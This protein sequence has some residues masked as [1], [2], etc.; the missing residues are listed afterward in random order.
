M[1]CPFKKRKIDENDQADSIA[2]TSDEIILSSNEN[3]IDQ[4]EIE[5][6]VQQEQ[7]DVVESGEG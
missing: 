3:K 4:M 2:I 6:V 7:A 1:E 5:E